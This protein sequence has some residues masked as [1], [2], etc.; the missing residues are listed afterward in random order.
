MS[1]KIKKICLFGIYA[2]IGVTLLAQV[3]LYSRFFYPFISTR[4]FIFRA[5]VEIMLFFYI[6]VSALSSLLGPDPSG[7]FWGDIERGE[8]I[9]MWLHLLAYFVI[10]AAVLRTRSAWNALL[11]S[12]LVMAL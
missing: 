3:L 6:A 9:I 2:G 11:D 10:L 12:S 8:G 1:Q 4:V 7:S 5:A